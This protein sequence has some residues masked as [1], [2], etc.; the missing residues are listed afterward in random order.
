M[1]HY[2]LGEGTGAFAAALAT[3]ACLPEGRRW[4][5]RTFAYLVS[6]SK[7]VRLPLVPTIDTTGLRGPMSASTVSQA[8][9]Q[10]VAGFT[11]AHVDYVTQVRDIILRGWGDPAFI[12]SVP[13]PQP[14]AGPP[15]KV[16]PLFARQQGFLGSSTGALS[17][18]IN[19]LLA[20]YHQG[21]GNLEILVAW[22]D[23][24]R[25]HQPTVNAPPLS[26]NLRHH[27]GQLLFHELIHSL[28]PRPKPS[29]ASGGAWLSYYQLPQE[30]TAHAGSIA[31]EM[32]VR[33]MSAVS[34]SPVARQIVGR[35][36]LIS[37]RRQVYR[38]LI[39]ETAVWIAC[40]Q[41]LSVPP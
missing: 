24:V 32:R 19:A 40:L 39:A 12:A 9:Q 23:W 3:S 36:R 6:S 16:K 41:P 34:H 37:G 38:D 26:P 33:G 28:D 15:T 25:N 13:I 21:T 20:Q 11:Q 30:I 5:D 35:L 4:P 29:G 2:Y 1:D 17:K 10:I 7:L 22:P 14:S 31:W 27:L 8:Q 18:P